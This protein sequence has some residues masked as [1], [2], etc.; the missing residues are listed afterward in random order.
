MSYI[1]TKL[2]VRSFSKIISRSVY[3]SQSENLI[4]GNLILKCFC[5]T[6]R[7]RIIF[8]WKHHFLYPTCSFKI[9]TVLKKLP[10]SNTFHDNCIFKYASIMLQTCKC[11]AIF[12]WFKEWK[13]EYFL[14]LGCRVILHVFFKWTVFNVKIKFQYL[15]V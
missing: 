14:Y 11:R 2:S 10:L 13:L 4:T 12:Y 6:E 7:Q 1:F 9:H 15:N 3:I 5:F 8:S